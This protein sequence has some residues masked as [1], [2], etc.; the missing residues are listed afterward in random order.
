[1]PERRIPV[2]WMK[3]TAGHAWT[4]LESAKGPREAVDEGVDEG[5]VEGVEVGL[6]I[7]GQVEVEIMDGEIEAGE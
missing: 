3:G 2:H 5:G 4:R 1:M 7:T 6:M